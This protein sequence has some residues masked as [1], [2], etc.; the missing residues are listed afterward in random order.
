MSDIGSWWHLA[1]RFV[2]V[3]RAKALTPNQRREVERLLHTAGE[4]R[5]FFAQS[6]A[7]QQHGLAAARYASPPLQRA[8]LLHDVGKQAANLGVWGRVM[9]SVMAKLHI[10]VR[11][12]FRIYLDHGPIGATMLE[13]ERAEPIVVAYARHHHDRRPAFVPQAEWIAL[14]EADRKARPDMGSAIR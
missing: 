10:P 3:W 6:N 4:R 7:D 8:A 11:G 9:A 1:R 13:A 5:I 12:R 2:E 14:I